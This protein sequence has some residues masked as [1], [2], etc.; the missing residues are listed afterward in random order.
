LQH[1]TH[2]HFFNQVDVDAGPL[3]GG[4]DGHGA[5]I[6][7]GQGAEATLKRAH[8]GAGG[9]NDNDRVGHADFSLRLLLMFRRPG[10]SARRRNAS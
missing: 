2:E 9:G 8:G 3:D 4:L 1:A 6:G 7:R 5:E 10:P